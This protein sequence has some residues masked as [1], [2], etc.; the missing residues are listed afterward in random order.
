MTNSKINFY[1][2]TLHNNMYNTP[3]I[4]VGASNYEKEKAKK[5]STN[6]RIR[7]HM[8]KYSWEDGFEADFVPV[9]AVEST[10]KTCL[11]E[12]FTHKPIYEKTEPAMNGLSYTSKREAKVEEL[13]LISKYSKM[14]KEFPD[15]INS[16][17]DALNII[18]E[19][20]I[21]EY[22]EYID[23]LEELEDIYN[24]P[25]IQLRRE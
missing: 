1:V 21:K 2:V 16:Y 10:D 20:C 9:L 5:E 23:A 13:I 17:V 3:F 22:E 12:Y 15:T 25:D 6:E 24:S 4:S 14:L 18:E 8:R 19:G 7:C 11:L